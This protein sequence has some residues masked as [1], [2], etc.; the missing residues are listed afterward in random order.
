ML[1]GA[2]EMDSSA[3]PLLWGALTRYLGKAADVP[4]CEWGSEHPAAGEY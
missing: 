4:R 2:A 3:Q 1:L